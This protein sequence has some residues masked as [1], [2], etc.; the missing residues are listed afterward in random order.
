MVNARATR[1]ELNAEDEKISDLEKQ[2]E[3]LLVD[4]C[5]LNEGVSQIR[6]ENVKTKNKLKE[7]K[8][9]E[10]NIEASANS[11]QLKEI[12][13]T[14]L[15]T[16][17]TEMNTFKNLVHKRLNL[18]DPEQPDDVFTDIPPLESSYAEPQQ[19]QTPAKQR[20]KRKEKQKP[21]VENDNQRVN[22]VE[23]RNRGTN[24]VQ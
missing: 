17:M 24:I 23:S 19:P 15:R 6:E 1:N 3:A 9:K 16:F 22:T 11:K 20:K 18:H 4:V 21:M 2:N 7:C 12:S 10:S 13:T 14:E 8:S 5:T